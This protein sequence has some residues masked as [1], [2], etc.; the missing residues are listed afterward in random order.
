MPVPHLWGTEHLEA[1]DC[2]A[3]WTAV[4]LQS[5]RDAFHP[6]PWT[7]P[8]LGLSEGAQRQAL[9]WLLSDDCAAVIALCGYDPAAIQGRLAHMVARHQAGEDVLSRQ[10][11]HAAARRRRWPGQ[12][13]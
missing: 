13:A 2:R 8:S 12:A 1:R 9:K 11:R 3:L 7:C 5:V 6:R 10:Q 4:L